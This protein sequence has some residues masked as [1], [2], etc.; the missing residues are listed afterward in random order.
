MSVLACSK[1][2]C[3]NI[4]CN[5]YSIRYGYICSE[6]FD[7]LVELGAD[8][9]ISEFMHREKQSDNDRKAAK[10]RFEVEFPIDGSKIL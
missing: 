9:N 1:W 4:N 5:R 8:T 3:D 2:G 6:C 10:V 7:E